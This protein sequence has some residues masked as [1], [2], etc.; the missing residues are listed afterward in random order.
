MVEVIQELTDTWIDKQSVDTHAREYYLALKRKKILIHTLA[1][2]N[3]RNI[4]L[5][6]I[7]SYKG[8][9]LLWSIYMR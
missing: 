8:Q 3:L 6:E 4:I 1:Q 5:N 7:N 9:I 2:I